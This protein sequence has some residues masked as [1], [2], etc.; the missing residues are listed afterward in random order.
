MPS[1]S[2]LPT[3]PIHRPV[4]YV[5]PCWVPVVAD[6]REREVLASDQFETQ[7]PIFQVRKRSRKREGCLVRLEHYRFVGRVLH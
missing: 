6:R 2:P 4:S 1:S 7:K 3:H 5:N